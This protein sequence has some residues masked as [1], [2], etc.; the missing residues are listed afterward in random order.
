MPRDFPQHT[1]RALEGVVNECIVD[2]AC[3]TAFPNLRAEVKTVL[4][5]LLSGPVEAD[6]KLSPDG[7]STRVKLSRDLAAEAIR[8]MLYQ[9]GTANRIPLIIHL[10]AQGNFSPL[11]ESAVFFRQQIVATGS[12]GMYLS[13]TCAEDLPWIKAGEGERNGTNTF[14]GDYRLRQQREACT[15]WPR[16]KIPKNYAAPTRSKVQALILTGEWD[17]VT[18][19]V[20]AK[21][22]ARYLPNS[23][24]IVVPSGGHGFNGLEGLDCIS[25]LMAEFI[26]RGTVKGLDSSCVKKIHRKGFL[27]KDEEPV[28]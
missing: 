18:P 19:P 11:A 4:D 26:N 16:G 7:K 27:L 1:Q 22:A 6:V 24:N 20:Y 12:N 21:T 10:A 3:R 28:K 8:Y 25:N 17:P 2:E 5:K 23:L 9:T 15:F 13:V 14:L